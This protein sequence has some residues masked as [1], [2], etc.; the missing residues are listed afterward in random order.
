[1]R[2]TGASLR[3]MIP[4]DLNQGTRTHDWRVLVTTEELEKGKRRAREENEFKD[5]VLSS[6]IFFKDLASGRNRTLKGQG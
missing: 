4:V 3:G 2:Y 6:S 5:G 1:M